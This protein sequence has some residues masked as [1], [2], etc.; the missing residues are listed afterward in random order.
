MAKPGFQ[1]L[2]MMVDTNKSGVVCRK[3]SKLIKMTFCIGICGKIC[4]YARSYKLLILA[5]I[6]SP[7]EAKLKN[8]QLALTRNLAIK[9]NEL[10]KV[11]YCTAVQLNGNLMTALGFLDENVWVNLQMVVGKS[12]GTRHSFSNLQV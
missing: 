10:F 9:R 4:A 5:G 3:A 1:V 8:D 2:F 6:A 11:I 7:I 12:S